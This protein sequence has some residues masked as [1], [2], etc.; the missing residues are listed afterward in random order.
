M[1]VY[2]EGIKNN[3]IQK[4][5]ITSPKNKCT[6]GAT[7]IFEIKQEE[8]QRYPVDI[9]RNK[10]DAKTPRPWNTLLLKSETEKI[11]LQKPQKART[12]TGKCD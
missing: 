3:K 11:L 2:I 7:V 12:K 8:K 4:F 6:S 1:H 9:K 5:Q 10:S